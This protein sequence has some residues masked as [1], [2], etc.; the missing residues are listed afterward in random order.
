MDAVLAQYREILKNRTGQTIPEFAAEAVHT[1]PIL[2]LLERPANSGAAR[3]GIVQEHNDD[4][5]ARRTRRMINRAGLQS[6]QYFIWNF[7]A[8]I[9]ATKTDRRIW[10][11]ETQ[12]LIAIMPKLKVVLVF[13]NDAWLGM[14]DVELP[15][16]VALIGAPHPSDRGVNS[17]KLVAEGKIERAWTRAKQLIEPANNTPIV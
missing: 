9:E 13:G 12:Q 2:A 16:G 4:P 3:S 17:D 6:D 5:T 10:A 8:S 11:R 14:R 15:K 1:A 7:Y